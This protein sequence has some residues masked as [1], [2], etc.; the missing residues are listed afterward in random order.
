MDFFHLFILWPLLKYIGCLCFSTTAIVLFNIKSDTLFNVIQINVKEE[1]FKKK[2]SITAS[3][4]RW[5]VVNL[6]IFFFFIWIYR[7]MLDT[8]KSYIIINFLCSIYRFFFILCFCE[9]ISG[10]NLSITSNSHLQVT[11]AIFFPFAVVVVVF[12]HFSNP[13]EQNLRIHIKRNN[14]LLNRA[15]FHFIFKYQM[16]HNAVANSRY[17]FK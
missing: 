15:H 9:D 2:K 12:A 14:F 10:Q 7:S 13:I 16:K 11:N 4:C 6:F 1:N 5:L 8:I 3:Q 17:H